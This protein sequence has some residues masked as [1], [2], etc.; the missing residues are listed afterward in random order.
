MCDLPIDINDPRISFTRSPDTCPE[1]VIK[2]TDPEIM[3]TIAELI[4]KENAALI[5]EAKKPGTIPEDV[6]KACSDICDFVCRY[7]ARMSEKKLK[8]Q[9]NACP[10][11][12]IINYIGG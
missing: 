11:N 10:L 6:E 1:M 2:I 5:P 3:Q 7:P 9:C 8:A 12:I 4:A